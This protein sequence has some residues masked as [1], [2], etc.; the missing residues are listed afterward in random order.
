MSIHA[1]SSRRVCAP[2]HGSFWWTYTLRLSGTERVELAGVAD[3]ER[4]RRAR[5][6]P[7]RAEVEAR[8]GAA[9]ERSL[10]G[11]RAQVAEACTAV[12][13]HIQ[14][15][16]PLREGTVERLRRTIRRFRALNFVDDD[17]LAGELAAFEQACLDGLDPGIVQETPDVRALL[18]AG[19]QAVVEAATTELPRSG[20]TGR[21]LR[22]FDVET[23]GGD[24]TDDAERIRA[25]SDAPTAA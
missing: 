1:L 6:A 3:V 11:F 21:A 13:G 22:R 15:G 4:A 14:S 25:A 24:G 7:Y 16:R 18:T 20:L 10:A 17:A 5:D 8:I 19:L 2:A 23:Q 12:L 9:L